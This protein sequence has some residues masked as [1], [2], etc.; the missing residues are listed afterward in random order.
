MCMA[1]F[2]SPAAA[3]VAQSED[4]NPQSSLFRATVP[5][6]SKKTFLINELATGKNYAA[7]FKGISSVSS[8]FAPSM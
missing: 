5:H 7:A 1:R 3:C 8:A 6:G 4:L 2:G